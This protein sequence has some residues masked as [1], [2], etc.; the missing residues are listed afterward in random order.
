MLL[1][2][3]ST[4]LAALA[5][6]EVRVW[7]DSQGREVPAEMT[8]MQGENVLLKM[9]D[10]RI[11]P[12]PLAQL[13]VPDQEFARN[14]PGRSAAA[15]SW[16]KGMHKGDLAL[17]SASQLTFGPAG[18]LFIGD[19]RAAAIIAL[20]TGDSSSAAPREVKV[21]AIDQKLA[22]LLGTSVDQIT[23]QDIAVNP[24]S[25][26]VYIAIARG[27][28]PEAAALIAKVDAKGDIQ[29]VPLKNA[30]FSRAE[31]A[32]APGTGQRQESITDIAFFEDRLLVAGLSNEEFSSSFRAI[33]FP[34]QK[35][36]KGA[37]VEIFHGAH[38]KFETRSPVRTFLPIKIGGQP[39]LL[40]AYTCTPLVQIPIKDLIP[41]AKIRGKTVAELGNG[42]RPLDMILYEKSGKQFVLMANSS[43]GIMKINTDNLENLEGIT[44][45]TG[46]A[47]Q[48]YE[49]VKNWSGVEQLDTFN[50]QQALALRREGSTLNLE[51]L[52]LP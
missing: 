52:S 25:K 12:F 32:D 20:A 7:K 33:P 26:N 34:F 49:T 37:G 1:V 31:L 15:G 10:G 27:K 30:L 40:A 17:Q 42:N 45:Q 38:G 4:G 47:G 6:A 3:Y 51:T 48:P 29:P 19:T 16:Q 43:R 21:E 14:N 35:V 2:L 23:I 39:S 18:V 5:T 22:A 41:G 50:A 11:I 36:A 44:S 28:G 24:L 13:S 9:R 46:V 8:G